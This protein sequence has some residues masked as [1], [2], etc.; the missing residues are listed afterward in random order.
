MSDKRTNN[1]S[2][3]RSIRVPL[4]TDEFIKAYQKDNDYPSYASTVVA[5]ADEK[6]DALLNEML[7]PSSK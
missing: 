7:K 6:R 3:N 1:K 5:I 4:N 2:V